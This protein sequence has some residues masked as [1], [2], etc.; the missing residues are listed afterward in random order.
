MVAQMFFADEDGFQEYR[1]INAEAHRV[2]PA[3]FD[4]PALI[5]HQVFW[6][7]PRSKQSDMKERRILAKNAIDKVFIDIAKNVRANLDP[8]VSISPSV[9]DDNI[10]ILFSNAADAKTFELIP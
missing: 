10:A 5:S 1:Q 9:D 7:A 2:R 8:K 6:I 4:A 3:N